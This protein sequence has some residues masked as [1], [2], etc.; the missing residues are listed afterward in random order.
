MGGQSSSLLSRD[1]LEFLKCN[2]AY[3]EQT[4]VEIYKGFMSDCP[5]GKL[6]P[7]TF[8]QI[9]SKCFPSGNAGQFC[10]HVFRCFDT[11]DN[12]VIDFKEF[13]LSMDINCSGTPE[14][15]LNWAFRMYDVDGNGYIDILEM[16]K[17]VSSIYKMIGSDQA[18][19]FQ[20]QTPM[21]RAQAIFQK[22]DVNADGKVTKDE[23]TKT[24]LEDRNLINLLA[25]ASQ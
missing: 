15:K 21:E 9:Y 19:L 24:C 3:D 8:C 10:K 17:L 20:D 2:T 22:M 25:P 12:G 5:E 14:E 4:I 13:L 11:D 6:S 7:T 1:D 18:H 16:T 23:F